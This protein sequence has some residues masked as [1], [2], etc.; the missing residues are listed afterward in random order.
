MADKEMLVTHIKGLGCRT[1]R[2]LMVHSIGCTLA[3]ELEQL[4]RQIASLQ[5]EVE[6]IE[7][8]LERAQSVQRSV[9][10]QALLKEHGLSDAKFARLSQIDHE[11]QEELRK[12][13]A[14]VPGTEVQ[15]D[16][17]LDGLLEQ[18]DKNHG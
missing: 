5:G 13:I 6:A 16:K 1:K 4:S 9:E 17:L 11:L 3:S 8:V 10:R 7:V 18:G 2:E 15:I 14:T 12:I